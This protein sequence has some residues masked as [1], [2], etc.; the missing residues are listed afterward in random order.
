MPADLGYFDKLPG[1]LFIDLL[2]MMPARSLAKM[3]EISSGLRESV[4][5]YVRDLLSRGKII[6]DM[7]MPVD[8]DEDPGAILAGLDAGAYARDMDMSP[9]SV[10]EV[11]DKAMLWADRPGD[12]LLIETMYNEASN[13]RDNAPEP[14][15]R[16]HK[17]AAYCLD[18]GRLYDR[19]TDDP[20]PSD[21]GPT[22]AL[23]LWARG[24]AY[25]GRPG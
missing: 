3:R 12:S 19:Q 23:E 8:K 4:N 22:K 1:E 21:T 7:N 16:L 10:I 17:Y 25:Y 15:E 14:Y 20:L 24:D 13:D 18:T 6:D 9:E 5:G 11:L 2:D